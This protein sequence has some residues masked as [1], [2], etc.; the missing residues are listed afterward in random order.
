MYF[1][2]GSVCPSD[3]SFS[4]FVLPSYPDWSKQLTFDP[5]SLDL[6]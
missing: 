6:L 5:Y 2:N 3:D 1:I 4:I